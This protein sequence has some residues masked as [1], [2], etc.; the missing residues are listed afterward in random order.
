MAATSIEWCDH[1]INPIRARHRA[2]G[3]VGHYCERVS[4]GCAHCERVSLTQPG[5]ALLCRVG[6]KA[7]GRLLDGREWNEFPAATPRRSPRA[8]R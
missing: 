3:A 8:L 4:P 1:S 2:T 7:A 6:K 5:Y